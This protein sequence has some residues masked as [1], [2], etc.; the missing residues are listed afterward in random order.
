MNN[1]FGKKLYSDPTLALF[2]RFSSKKQ[3]FTKWVIL[4]RNAV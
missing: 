4:K 2:R 1:K 3:T